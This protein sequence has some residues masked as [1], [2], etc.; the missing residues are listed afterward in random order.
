MLRAVVWTHL[1][2]GEMCVG[3]TAP[4]ADSF[5][6]RGVLTGKVKLSEFDMF[7]GSNEGMS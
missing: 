3:F 2:F 4:V 5:D 6:A 1:N 7:Q